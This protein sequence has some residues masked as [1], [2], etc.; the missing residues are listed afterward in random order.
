LIA[1]R[2]ILIVHLMGLAFGM[3]GATAFDAIFLVSS[4][5]G[6]VTHDLVEVVHTA[7]NLVAGAMIMLVISGIAFFEVGA[8]PTPKF[9]AKMVIVGIACLNGVV[10]HRLVFPLIETAASSRAGYLYLQPWH[11]RLAATSAAVSGVSWSAALILGAWHGLQLGL[12]P[13]LL[14]YAGILAVAVLTSSIIIAP[15]IFVFEPIYRRSRRARAAGLAQSLALAIGYRSFALAGRLG[16]AGSWLDL[17][18]FEPRT[19]PTYTPESG[20]RPV[21]DVPPGNRLLHQERFD[22]GDTSPGLSSRDWPDHGHD[23]GTATR[24]R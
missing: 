7:A 22:F 6:K 9:W 12:V 17:D 11:A 3:G 4:R 8:Q 21:K 5:R 2:I 13:I 20:W 15:R 14:A 10:A 18:E 16:D 24:I 19:V 23:D 1:Y